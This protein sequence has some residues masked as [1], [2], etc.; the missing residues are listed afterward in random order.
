MKRKIGQIWKF[1]HN[2]RNEYCMLTSFDESTTKWSTY[3][4]ETH[5]KDWDFDDQFDTECWIFIQ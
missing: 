4:I 3:N 2:G 1:T 5:E